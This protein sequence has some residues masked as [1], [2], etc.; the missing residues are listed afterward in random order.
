MQTIEALDPIDRFIDEHLLFPLNSKENNSIITAVVTT[1][2][3]NGM[4]PGCL[5]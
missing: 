1:L 5:C 4:L 3:D 2:V